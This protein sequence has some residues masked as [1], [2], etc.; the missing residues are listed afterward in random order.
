MAVFQFSIVYPAS[1]NSCFHRCGPG[2]WECFHPAVQFRSRR[3]RCAFRMNLAADRFHAL[4]DRLLVN[5]QA[6]VI[7]TV[8]YKSW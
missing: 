7:H 2:L 4:A 5:V 8:L 3:L 1:E 6:D